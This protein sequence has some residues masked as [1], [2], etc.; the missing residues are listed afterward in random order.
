MRKPTPDA[1]LKGRRAGTNHARVV[2]QLGK[3]IVSGHFPA[4]GLLPG[5]A[6][7]AQRFQVSRTVLRE[8]LKTLDAKGLISPRVRIGTSVRC[9]RDWNHFDPE[10]L[11]WYIE[12]GIDA[13][14]L[15]QIQEI[16]LAFEPRA[17]ALAAANA[18]DAHVQAITD[19]IHSF[20]S[21]TLS[22]PDVVSTLMEVHAAIADASA[23]VFIQSAESLLKAALVGHFHYDAAFVEKIAERAAG[24]YRDLA[25][26]I[27]ERDAPAAF[28]A[29]E[30][31]LHSGFPPP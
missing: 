23:N 4:G 30:A 7:L 5:D 1:A 8:A 24:A 29:M 22:P 14:L 25:C 31:V 21:G 15:G 28:A 20:L 13:R 9:R 12:S 10:V 19:R 2:Q 3:D 16:R 6:E 27:R 18:S 26:S 17:A 11:L